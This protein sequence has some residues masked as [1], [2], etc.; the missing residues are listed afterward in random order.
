MLFRD[1]SQ[2]GNR[3]QL[4]NGDHQ[5]F[6]RF[7]S[8]QLLQHVRARETR[9]CLEGK[10]VVQGDLQRSLARHSQPKRCCTTTIQTPNHPERA[11]GLRNTILRAVPRCIS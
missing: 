3:Y 8:E 4:C 1:I 9:S 2:Q 5:N 6:I 11:S 10:C 7:P